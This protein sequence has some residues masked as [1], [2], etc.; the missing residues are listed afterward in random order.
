MNKLTSKTKGVVAEKIK[1]FGTIFILLYLNP[2]TKE[3]HYHHTSVYL[4]MK[5]SVEISYF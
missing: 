4:L 1:V 2:R 5:I 3:Y